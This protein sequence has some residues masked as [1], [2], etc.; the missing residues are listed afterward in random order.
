MAKRND[1]V[2]KKIAGFYGLIKDVYPVKKI[3]LYGSYAKGL[4]TKDSDIDVA[5]VVDMP[6]HRKRVEITADLFHYAGMVDCNI[7]PKCIFWDE[8][9]KHE[10]ASILA[11][12]I[13]TGIE[14]PF[15]K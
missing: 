13:K 9:K 7:E 11:E 1:L 10:K 8:Y 6:S 15:R 3:I 14:V 4:A 5:V 12:I 2:K